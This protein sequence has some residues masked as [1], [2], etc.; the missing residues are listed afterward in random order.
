LSVW[1]DE[2]LEAKSPSQLAGRPK[3]ARTPAFVR[4]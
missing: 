3:R 4:L 1:G 2:G